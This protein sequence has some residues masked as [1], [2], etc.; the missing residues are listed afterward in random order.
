MKHTF[1]VLISLALLALTPGITAGQ[2][3]VRDYEV[4]SLRFEGN[5]SLAADQLLTV[6]R[7]RETPWTFWKFLYNNISEKLGQKPEYFD[8]I[9]FD[10]DF[11]QLKR[12]YEDNG[13]YHA[14]IDT[15]VEIVSAEKEVRLAFLIREGPR[16]F[17]DSLEFRG[18][19]N[20]P[21]DV[22]DEMNSGKLIELHGPFRAFALEQEV[23]RIVNTFA[24][25]GYVNVK[26]D[27]VYA[28][29]YASTNNVSVVMAFRPGQRYQF[30]EIMVQQDSTV[31]ERVDT[32]IVFDH[33]DYTAG[34]F[35]SESK[36]TESERN[37][38][39][40][41][42]FET[43]K[44]E[45][46]L[47]SSASG[48]LQ[49]PTRVLVRPRP[50]QE[51]SPEI[52]INDQDNA[53]N[54]LTG[55][56]YSH[57]N[58]FG[59]ARNFSTRLRFNLQSINRVRLG[60]LFN[61]QWREDSTLVSKVEAS[62]QLLQPYFL[63]N[64]T[65]ISA[66]LSGIVDKREAY[67]LPILRGRIS[68]ATQTAT[69]TRGYLDWDLERIDPKSVRTRTDTSIGEAFVRQFNSIIALTIQ[70]DKRNDLFSP[71]DGFFHSV[72]IEEAGTL[73]R[74]TGGLFGTK[75]PFSQYVKLSGVGQWYWDPVGDRSWIWAARLR[76]GA[77]VLYGASQTGIPLTRKF[78]AGGSGSVRG[79]KARDLGAVSRTDEGGD[80]LLEGNLEGRWNLFKNAGKLAFIELGKFSI[81]LFYD[82][83]DIWTEPKQIRIQE[84]AMATGFGLRY[85]TIAGPIR[86][87]FGMRVY[88]PFADPSQRWVTQKRFFPE[89]FSGGVL[90]FGVG[91]TF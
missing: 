20:L 37:L 54:I 5:E 15:M 11:A 13:F 34:D 50:F 7:T 14:Q 82:A 86:I 19:G 84:I 73:P 24:N 32:G 2:E 48:L 25:N 10:S 30:G 68:V 41:G 16:S 47:Q 87:D 88:D 38:N 90:H 26:V 61:G 39:R 77:G 45:N 43:T 59:G 65:T 55:V 52:G 40:L 17:I 36:K 83:G 3:N 72:T 23:S 66:T 85:D 80:A 75:L 22:V 56:G 21:P 12:Y 49:I 70:R 71:S 64:K 35:Y 51:L 79:W 53:L 91:H 46:M 1:W 63:N 81:V 44:I 28:Q 76:G 27:T 78:F 8:P 6:V 42:I 89:T 57:R 33:L 74:M 67:Y 9:L 60:D 58:F 69:Y 31:E 62:A 29:R 18:L 4:A